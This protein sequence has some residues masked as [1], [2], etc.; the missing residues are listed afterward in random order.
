MSWKF[1]DVA[2]VEALHKERILR[3]GGS[4]GL[5]DAGLLASAV[6]R[7]E[8]KAFYE[9]DASLAAIGGTLCFGL[10]KNHAFVDGN[11]RVGLAAMVVF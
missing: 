10:V 1:L 9:P 8:M 6:S 3:F 11:K 7:A 2:G 5:R 4:P